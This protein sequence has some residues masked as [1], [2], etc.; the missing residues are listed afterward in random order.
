[1]IRY[2]LL[3]CFLPI[4]FSCVDSKSG[5]N[6]TS[7]DAKNLIQK[8]GDGD[9]FVCSNPESDISDCEQQQYYNMIDPNKE[10]DS[11]AKFQSYHGFDKAK[12]LNAI[13]RNE[14]DLNLLRD[15]YCKES[16]KPNVIACYVTNYHTTD[17]YYS[18]QALA[19][20]AMEY[21][22]SDLLNPVKFFAFDAS[23]DKR[24]HDVTLDSEGPKTVP[25]VCLNCHGGSYDDTEKSIKK[26]KFI[27]FDYELYS[28]GVS[29]VESE[30][31]SFIKLNKLLEKTNLYQSVRD[32]T[33]KH[34]RGLYDE[35]PSKWSENPALYT[36]VVKP[37]CRGC[38]YSFDEE[39]STFNTY[40]EFKAKAGL[41]N[42]YVCDEN[43]LM[44][45]SERTREL[46]L[47]S[48]GKDVLADF[49]RSQGK[50]PLNACL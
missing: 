16:I 10:R 29:G 42:V 50:T 25:H 33:K 26:A 7:S 2:F 36:A 11:L 28:D 6:G 20:V 19:T 41:I 5:V 40:E 49:L 14:F 34:S 27:M 12:P 15:M 48:E 44:P 9:L 4:Y 45:H 8:G 3:A 31:N 32:V 21:D 47:K 18:D 30:K 38:H 35:V 13:Y 23:G 1:M 24:L 17:E 43:G 46:F 22:P 39:R 37:F